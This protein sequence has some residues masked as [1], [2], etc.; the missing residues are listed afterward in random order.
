MG[1]SAILSYLGNYKI[2]TMLRLLSYLLLL[3]VL[4]VNIQADPSSGV[5]CCIRTKLGKLKCIDGPCKSRGRRMAGNL[6]QETDCSIPMNERDCTSS[7]GVCFG[8]NNM[9]NAPTVVPRPRE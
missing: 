2:S 9:G 5:R 7:P 8:T 6:K 4:M 3:L 1:N